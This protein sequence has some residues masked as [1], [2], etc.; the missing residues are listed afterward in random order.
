AQSNLDQTR[1]IIAKSKT[2][3]TN[4]LST[5]EELTSLLIQLGKYSSAN[6]LLIK[7]FNEYEKLYGRNSIRLVDPLVE[8]G[9]ILLANGEYT[10]AE[11]TAQ[12][13]YQ[14]AS[15]A[16]GANSTKTAPTQKLL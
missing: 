12:R 3:V 8:K 13:A 5:A 14:I 15:T 2:P 11:R 1:K 16:F 4:E 6:E 9:R 10:E 7:L